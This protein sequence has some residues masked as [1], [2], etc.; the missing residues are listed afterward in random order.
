MPL[1]LLADPDADT[2]QMYGEFLR[3]DFD[4]D[5][6]ED[7]RQALVKALS[8]HPSVVV[9]ETRLPYVSGLELCRELRRDELTESIPIIMLTADAVA[10][11]LQLAEASGADSVLIK[12]CLPEQL[13]AEVHQL[14]ARSTAL[15]ERART[16]RERVGRQ[17][18]RSEDLLTR[19]EDLLTRSTIHVGRRPANRIHHRGETLAPP[20]PP[21]DLRCPSCYRPMTYLKSQIGG[22]NARNPEQWDYFECAACRMVVEYRQRTRRLRNVVA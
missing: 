13:A 16:L 11:D 17:L 19:S 10:R 2:R 22:V 1:A 3:V 20:A 12:P 5:E 15:R 6:A 18:A 8:L 4:I 9:T 14:L 21:P 7:G